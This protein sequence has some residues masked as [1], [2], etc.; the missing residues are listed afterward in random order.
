M[1]TTD[2]IEF[3]E[4]ENYHRGKDSGEEKQRASTFWSGVQNQRMTQSDRRAG[5]QPVPKEVGL[6]QTERTGRKTR[7]Q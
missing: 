4:F 3:S 7:R 2:K 6:N 5:T 1:K